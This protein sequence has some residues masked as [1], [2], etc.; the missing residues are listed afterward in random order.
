LLDS[1]ITCNTCYHKKTSPPATHNL[2]AF[3]KI[4]ASN[5]RS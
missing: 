2:K 5:I 4:V 1:R 3:I